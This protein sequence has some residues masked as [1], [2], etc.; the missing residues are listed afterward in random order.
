M[1]DWVALMLVFTVLFAAALVILVS[2]TI[3]Y[4]GRYHSAFG[5]IDASINNEDY[6]SP[7][8]GSCEMRV[9]DALD[10]PA[11]APGF[12]YPVARYCADLVAR[13]ELL[14]YKK[15]GLAELSVPRELDLV[16]VL[17][18]KSKTI[19]FLARSR[20]TR[21]AWVAFRG[22]ATT[23]EWRKDFDFSQFEFGHASTEF[24][25]VDG[26]NQLALDSGDM[27]S[28]HK[29]FTDVYGEFKHDLMSAL[30]QLDCARAVV[31][32]HSLGGSL[33]TLAAIDIA[34]TLPVQAYV[35]GTP[36]VC[37]SIPDTFQLWR[38]NNTADPIPSF[39]LAVMPNVRNKHRPFHYTHG[40]VPIDFTTNR[41]SMT[42]NHLLPVYIDA[43]DN[44]RLF[45]E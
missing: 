35:F 8:E 3:V 36:R 33:A 26:Q 1:Q 41:R 39:P 6:C 17:T 13:V 11:P 18:F 12:D 14:F 5:A 42:N 31:T 30:A 19:G 20:A 25:I 23:A 10:E 34:T 16:T 44:R 2:V 7:Q 28:C 15:K 40:G 4:Y 32:G 43:L 24:D 27:L 45:I 37:E 22:T 9:N 38:V 29:G 21:T